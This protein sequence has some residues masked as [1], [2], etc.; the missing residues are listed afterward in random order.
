VQACGQ[1]RLWKDLQEDGEAV[2]EKLVVG[3][4]A[5]VGAKRSD[6]KARASRASGRLGGRPPKSATKTDASDEGIA[7]T[8]C[9]A[10]IRSNHHAARRS[11]STCR[12]QP[13]SW[14][15]LAKLRLTSLCSLSR[16]GCPPKPS[17]SDAKADLL[18][19]TRG[20][21]WQAISRTRP[22]SY[23]ARVDHPTR[24]EAW[25]PGQ[26]SDALFPFDRTQI[27]QTRCM[28]DRARIATES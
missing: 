25:R 4:A 9:Q 24:C 16:G 26:P 10:G 21:R 15:Q 2:S 3:V 12:N 19:R 13:S 18:A 8:H 6:A 20:Y 11:P 5:L 27:V 23:A 1:P 22:R 7:L 14:F 28:L 17:R